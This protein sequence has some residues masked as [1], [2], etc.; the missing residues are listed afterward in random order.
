MTF[1]IAIFTLLKESEI[2]PEISLRYVLLFESS[3]YKFMTVCCKKDIIQ[4][5]I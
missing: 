2:K 3:F 1:F 5:V 4:A